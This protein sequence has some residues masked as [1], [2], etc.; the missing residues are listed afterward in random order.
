MS[1][2]DKEKL[3]ELYEFKETYIWA[4]VIAVILVIALCIFR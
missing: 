1:K 4:S 3:D 2:T